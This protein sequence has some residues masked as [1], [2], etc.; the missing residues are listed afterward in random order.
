MHK[1]AKKVHVPV[2]SNTI[3]LHSKFIYT[4]LLVKNSV[5]KTYSSLKYEKKNY[6]PT[7]LLTSKMVSSVTAN[8]HNFKD[9]LSDPL[10]TFSLLL[11]KI[12]HSR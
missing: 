5:E 11:G 3:E 1:I 2:K 4:V 8:L 9:G 7:Y 12:P 6:F 10:L